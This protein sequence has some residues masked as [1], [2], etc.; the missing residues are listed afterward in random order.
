M[1]F[2]CPT[3]RMRLDLTDIPPG[4]QFMCPG[5]SSKFFLPPQMGQAAL[6]PSLGASAPTPPLSPPLPPLGAPDY[7]APRRTSGMAIASM[8]LSIVGLLIY[9]LFP[10]LLVGVIFGFVSLSSIKRTPERL[11]GRGMALA[12]V[13]VGF[14]GITFWVGVAVFIAALGSASARPEAHNAAARMASANARI[15]EEVNFQNTRGDHGGR[16]ADQLSDLLKW[17]RS[18]TNDQAVTFTFGACNHS[19]Y[20]FTTTHANGDTSFLI[21]N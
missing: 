17:D 15:A 1:E 10:L 6:T 4:A 20:T 18:L 14:V 11:A 12:G 7:A 2:V 8:V 21:T 5:C 19:G 9:F 16:F 3:C 13:I